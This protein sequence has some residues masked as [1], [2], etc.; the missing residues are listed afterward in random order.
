LSTIDSD[1]SIKH[2]KNLRYAHETRSISLKKMN[3]NG[4]QPFDYLNFAKKDL[5]S[6]DIR[7]SINALGNTKRAVHITVEKLL[8]VFGLEKAYSKSKFPEKLNIISELEVFPV[9]IIR[10]LNKERNFVEHEYTS[11]PPEEVAKFIDITELLLLASYPLLRHVVTGAVIGLEENEEGYEWQV[12]VVESTITKSLILDEKYIQTSIGP[13]HYN[14]SDKMVVEPIE[15]IKISKNNQ[16]QWLQVMSL[17]AYLTKYNALQLNTE[18]NE[19]NYSIG[20]SR[21]TFFDI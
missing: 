17:F 8:W 16:N 6:N 21:Q 20:T 7:G 10:L 4:P 3:Q 11:I 14:F 18:K 15:Q 5:S 2:R 1:F 13:I 19:G 9:G 12:D